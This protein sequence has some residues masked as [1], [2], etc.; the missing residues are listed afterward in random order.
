MLRSLVLCAV[1]LSA[2]AACART[3]RATAPPKEMD[4]ELSLDGWISVESQHASILSAAGERRTLELAAQLERMIGV[5]RA[6][7]PID[8]SDAR[9]PATLFLF[10]SS[11]AYDYYRPGNAMAHFFESSRGYFI[12]VS[13]EYESRSV[14]FHE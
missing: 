3:P 7:G 4:R 14:L 11:D 6:T 9:V 8:V 13:P 10:S 2:L 1:A 5:L 12:L